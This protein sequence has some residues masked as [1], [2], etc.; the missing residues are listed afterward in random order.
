MPCFFQRPPGARGGLLAVEAL[1]TSNGVLKGVKAGPAMTVTS[2]LGA[3][4]ALATAFG[5]L[6][7]TQAAALASLA[8]AAGA[9]VAAVR[10]KSFDM[11]AL[12]AALG[13]VLQD[14]TLFNVHLTSGQVSA[15]VAGISVVIGALMHLLGADSPAHRAVAEAPASVPPV[16]QP[17]GGR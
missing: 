13:I 9:V 5:H 2:V 10:A 4:V 3:V 11:A 16:S 1:L 6:S 7:T 8:T 17:A 15:V 12:A 14:L